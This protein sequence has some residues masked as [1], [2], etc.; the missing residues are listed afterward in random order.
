MLRN[1]DVTI[2]FVKKSIQSLAKCEIG[3]VIRY[4]V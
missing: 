4:L 3:S 2:G 1:V